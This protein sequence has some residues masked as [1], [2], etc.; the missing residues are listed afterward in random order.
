MVDVR[1]VHG[2]TVVAVAATWPSPLSTVPNFSARFGR[3]LAADG[4]AV[5]PFALVS[6]APPVA[7]AEAPLLSLLLLLLFKFSSVLALPWPASAAT[8]AAAAAAAATAAASIFNGHLVPGKFV[9]SM[10][11]FSSLADRSSSETLEFRIFD[12][13]MS[14]LRLGVVKEFGCDRRAVLE[15]FLLFD[16]NTVGVGCTCASVFSLINVF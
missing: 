6:V 13:M 2:A 1:G 3:R 9:S 5:E 10:A 12:D 8:D 15:R 7:D 11:A 4:P 16:H 14:S